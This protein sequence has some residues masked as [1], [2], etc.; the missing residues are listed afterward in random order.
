MLNRNRER[1]V[2]RVS[3]LSAPHRLVAQPAWRYRVN[4]QAG[5]GGHPSILGRSSADHERA[6]RLRVAYG[7]SLMNYIVGRNNLGDV[8]FLHTASSQHDA[9]PGIARQSLWFDKTSIRVGHEAVRL[10]Y[11][12][13]DLPLSMPRDD[14][15]W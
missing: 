14:G 13:Y 1:P 12:M 2:V 5:V 3:S 9:V 10:P 15:S 11:T 4:F 8:E 7:W 6:L